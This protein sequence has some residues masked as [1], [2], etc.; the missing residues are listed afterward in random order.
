MNEW[1]TQ[2]SLIAIQNGVCCLIVY[3]CILFLQLFIGGAGKEV[4]RFLRRELYVL[5]VFRLQETELYGLLY[6]LRS[7]GITS[8]LPFQVAFYSPIQTD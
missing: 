6:G 3:K 7:H 1:I 2:S 8:R 5:T 4:N